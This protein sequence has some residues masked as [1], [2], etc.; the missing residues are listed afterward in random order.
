[1]IDNGKL[2]TSSL[3]KD[4]RASSASSGTRHSHSAIRDWVQ[5]CG[6]EKVRIHMRAGAHDRAGCYAH[7]IHAAY[8]PR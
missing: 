5:M 2:N 3:R 8:S 7:A 4:I 6:P 1:M